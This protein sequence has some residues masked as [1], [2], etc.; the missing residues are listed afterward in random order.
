MA[1]G[2]EAADCLSGLRPRIPLQEQGRPESI[3]STILSGQRPYPFTMNRH[4]QRLD[5]ITGGKKHIDLQ[6]MRSKTRTFTNQIGSHRQYDP[7]HM[8][9]RITCFSIGF[10][11]TLANL[12]LDM[13]I[14]K[15]N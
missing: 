12:Y 1:A 15:D 7:A 3:T 13:S 5:R 14:T 8:S 6:T 2:F 4:S 10:Q 9:P 11:I